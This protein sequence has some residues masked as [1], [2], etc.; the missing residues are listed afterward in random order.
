MVYLGNE[1]GTKAYRLFDPTTQKICVSRDVKFKENET[2][3]WK[4]YI[5]EHIN[6]EPKWTNF[7]IEN[8]EVTSKHHDQG[9]QPVEE[10]NEFPNSGDDGYASLTIGSPLHSQ[11]PH[12]P[13]TNSSHVNSQVTPNISTQSIYQNNSAYK[14]SLWIWFTPIAKY[15]GDLVKASG[16]GKAKKAV[17]LLYSG[18]NH[19]DLL[20]WRVGRS[21]VATGHL[22]DD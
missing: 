19:Y 8:L 21:T 12:T 1:Q 10:D 22:K 13:S 16:K 14:A 11:T 18:R 17:R 4:E 20:V 15:G 7:K 5:S 9:T 3:V 2:W 6:D